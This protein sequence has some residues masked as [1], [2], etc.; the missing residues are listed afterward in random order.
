[1]TETAPKPTLSTLAKLFYCAAVGLILFGAFTYFRPVSID[2]GTRVSCG[3]PYA[4]TEP[5]GISPTLSAPVVQYVC[6][7]R[8]DTEQSV[9]I[10]ALIGGLLIG[11]GTYAQTREKVREK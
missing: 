11:A 5:R 2:L 4:P 3:S 6:E 1:M 7:K 8:L 10:G 9:A